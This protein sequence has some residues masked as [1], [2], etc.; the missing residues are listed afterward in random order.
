MAI[1]KRVEKHIIN[2]EHP[3]FPMLIDKCH[4][5]KNIYNHANYIIRQEFINNGNWLRYD[6]IEQ[7]LHDDMEYPDYWNW[8]LANSSQQVLRVL[9]KNWKSFFKAIKEYNKNPEKFTGR[10]KLPKYIKKNGYKEFALTTQQVKLKKD[11]L[12]FLEYLLSNDIKM[13]IASATAIELIKIAAKHCN[14][15]KYF[16]AGRGSGIFPCCKN[17]PGYCQCVGYGVE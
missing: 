4:E 16:E 17:H 11:V 5:A 6:D 12:Q 2:R 7:M 8:N 14:I 9:D 3:Y 1:V 13:C 10:P 15:E